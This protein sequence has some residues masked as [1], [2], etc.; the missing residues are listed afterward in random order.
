MW[1][2]WE[3]RSPISHPLTV[4]KDYAAGMGFHC[5]LRGPGPHCIP[6]SVLKDKKPTS[7]NQAHV[8]P[9]PKNCKQLHRACF[10]LLLLRGVPFNNLETNSRGAALSTFAFFA[11]LLW[12]HWASSEKPRSS[13]P[14]YQMI[15]L[16]HLDPSSS[17]SHHL[18]MWYKHL[19]ECLGLRA[20]ESMQLY[21]LFPLLCTETPVIMIIL[22]LTQSIRCT[23]FGCPSKLCVFLGQSSLEWHCTE[24]NLTCVQW[25]GF[26]SFLWDF[27]AL[28]F[29]TSQTAIAQV[30]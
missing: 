15:S 24:L 28:V 8:N 18:S 27:D 23:L 7:H 9:H 25:E 26:A 29:W 2:W 5:C 13:C 10:L 17:P 1:G 4:C 11:S 14:S 30:A 6:F 19:F 16:F 12:N 21:F 3:A 22:K 20:L